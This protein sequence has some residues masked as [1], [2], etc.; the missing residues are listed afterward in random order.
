MN[1]RSRRIVPSGDMRGGMPPLAGFL[2]AVGL[3]V[4]IWA[5]LYALWCVV[6][7]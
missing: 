7:A 2:A 3:S 6:G 1:E 4:I 5:L